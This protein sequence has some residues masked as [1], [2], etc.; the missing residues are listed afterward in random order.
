MMHNA[1]GSADRPSVTS[2]LDNMWITFALV[3][4][5]G[6]P[7][8][9]L[10]LILFPGLPRSVDQY[11][12]FFPNASL[13]HPGDAAAFY[14]SVWRNLAMVL[15]S[16]LWVCG[17]VALYRS[18]KRPVMAIGMIFFGLLFM[19]MYGSDLYRAV[20][21]H[22]SPRAM[23]PEIAVDRHSLRC[24]NLDAAVALDDI[25][26]VVPHHTKG[27]SFIAIQ[28]DATA[29]AQWGTAPLRCRTTMLD[30]SM[31]EITTEIERR[32]ATVVR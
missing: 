5:V 31:P 4:S 28:L 7:L 30:A 19:G 13:A 24:R 1:A 32:L 22:V 23:T 9:F 25:R 3:W 10:G 12:P 8:L 11:L 21:G 27:G 17:A 29:A 18:G 20:V 26:A 6:L 15:F 16:G 14:F 2:S